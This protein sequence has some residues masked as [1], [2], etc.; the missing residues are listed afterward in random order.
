M[1]W[2][3]GL[4]KLQEILSDLYPT[5]ELS[6]EIVKKANVPSGRMTF[7]TASSSN[8]YS[9]LEEADRHGMVQ[10]VVAVAGQ[11]YPESSTGLLRAEQDYLAEKGPPSVSP[12]GKFQPVDDPRIDQAVKR[13]HSLRTEQ[14]KGNLSLLELFTGQRYL[15]RRGAFTTSVRVSPEL[16]ARLWK[17]RLTEEI[18]EDCVGE[19]MNWD[20]AAQ[21]QY[22]DLMDAV[23]EYATRLG[24]LV[25]EE[26]NLREY[27][28]WLRF[29]EFRV[30][31]QQEKEIT[32]TH[33]DPAWDETEQARARV[34]ELTTQL[35][36]ALGLGPA[37]PDGATPADGSRAADQPQV[38]PDRYDSSL[39]P[40]IP[41]LDPPI[42][43]VRELLLA[44]FT[45]EDLRRLFLY[46]SNPKLRPLVQRFSARAG[47]AD[48]VDE[49]IEYCQTRDLL[50]DLLDEVKQA[51]PRQYARF[52]PLLQG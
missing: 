52:E 45:A 12:T 2:N 11:E 22:L 32:R 44:A 51:N 49:T 35:E 13:L 34:V 40:G 21:S 38:T 23:G 48:M 26:I 9:I 37:Q 3:P 18:L 16:K 24:N 14:G 36:G 46:T 5:V 10:A 29:E 43:V 17:S 47:L 28:F 30:Q 31:L 7:S 6:R 15:L 8:W 4:T 42:S 27:N 39:R 41:A 33:T 20:P 19:A 1:P 25:Y 50:P